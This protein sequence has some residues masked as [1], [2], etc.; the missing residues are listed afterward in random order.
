MKKI[1][2]LLLLFSLF[3]KSHAQQLSK[4]EKKTLNKTI[5]SIYHLD[6][7]LRL[8]LMK[9]DTTYNIGM[10]EGQ[11]LPY[12]VKEQ[13]KDRY[14]SYKKTKDS[15][16]NAIKINDVKNTERLIAITKKYGFPN[17]KRLGVYPS[18]AYFIFVHS[19]RNYFKE[20]EELIE[21]EF[22]ESRIS[23]YEKAYIFW[24]TGGRK[25]SPPQ[26]GKDGKV[27]YPY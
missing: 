16:W 19:P 20:I 24:H 1:A 14:S 12:K 25:G 5:D 26:L 27:I 17:N 15:I 13:L 21:K 2:I 18:R 11:I 10:G 9:L 22:K 4:T 7:S 23:E 6:Q 3:H 8:L